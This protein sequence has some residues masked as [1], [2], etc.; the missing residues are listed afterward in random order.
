VT[1][2]AWGAILLAAALA[3]VAFH[4][5]RWRRGRMTTLQFGAGLVAR[6]GFILLGVLYAFDLE[7][8]WPRAPLYGRGVVGVG[9]LLNL[10][11]NTIERIRYARGGGAEPDE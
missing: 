8:R 10:T 6:V 2:A 5:W 4:A 7:Y 1:T 11:A 3:A 9:I